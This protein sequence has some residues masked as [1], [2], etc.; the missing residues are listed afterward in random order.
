MVFQVPMIQ[1]V[2]E[3]LVRC[4]MIRIIAWKIMLKAVA[5][6]SDNVATNILGYYVTNQY[7]KASKNQ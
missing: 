6:N 7:D 3:R 1:M 2:L 5:Q 4:L